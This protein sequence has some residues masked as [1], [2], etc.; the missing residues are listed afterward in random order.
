[1]DPVFATFV[2][3]LFNDTFRNNVVKADFRLTHDKSKNNIIK[4]IHRH[5]GLGAFNDILSD[6]RLDIFNATSFCSNYLLECIDHWKRRIFK[7]KV[8]QV[9]M[10]RRTHKA[11]LVRIANRRTCRSVSVEGIQLKDK[12]PNNRIDEDM[13]TAYNHPLAPYYTPVSDKTKK[14]RL[15]LL[16]KHSIDEGLQLET[17][18]RCAISEHTRFTSFYDQAKYS[19][20]K[21]VRWDTW[22]PKTNNLKQKYKPLVSPVPELT[23]KVK[24]KP[25]WTKLVPK[26]KANWIPITKVIN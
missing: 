21:S 5:I 9:P 17:I 15:H 20:P 4:I 26:V 10:Y 2:A 12:N 22:S 13:W 8:H 19:P 1:M 25:V 7:K 14:T 3:R 23:G 16:E 18:T 6:S 24:F 11:V